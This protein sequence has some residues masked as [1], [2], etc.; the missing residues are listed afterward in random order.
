[1]RPNPEYT[2]EEVQAL[3]MS[4]LFA[5][6]RV[7]DLAER[8]IMQHN[9]DLREASHT[10]GY[11][12]AQD[13][14]WAKKHRTPS[15]IDEEAREVVEAVAEVLSLSPQEVC[16]HRKELHRLLGEPTRF[17]KSAR[18]LS[19]VLSIVVGDN[20]FEVGHLSDEELH[21]RLSALINTSF[22]KEPKK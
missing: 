5:H 11:R 15:L 6:R 2:V 20:Y 14:A 4:G 8:R 9:G 19:R 3:L 13:V 10:L 1:L 16:E 18:F 17:K 7:R 12:L 22:G 21:L